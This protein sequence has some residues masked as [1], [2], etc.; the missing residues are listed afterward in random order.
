MTD[1]YTAMQVDQIPKKWEYL[2]L[3]IRPGQDCVQELN[4]AGN[5]GWELISIKELADARDVFIIL[6]CYF[7]REKA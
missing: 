6:Y 3:A 4:K 5:Q 1:R 7:K 2:E